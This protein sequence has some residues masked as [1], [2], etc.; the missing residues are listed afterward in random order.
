MD[1]VNRERVEELFRGVFNRLQT[2]GR[3]KLSQLKTSGREKFSQIKTAGRERLAHSA[4]ARQVKQRRRQSL[5]RYG[6]GAKRQ[7]RKEHRKAVKAYA[8]TLKGGDKNTQREALR[9]LR[10]ARMKS[11]ELRQGKK[12]KYNPGQKAPIPG[13]A[14]SPEL[15]GEAPGTQYRN[16]ATRR[17]ET[18]KVRQASARIY[19]R[20]AEAIEEMLREGKTTGS[21]L[22][23]TKKRVE[24]FFQSG[25]HKRK[26]LMGRLKDIDKAHR[27][28]AKAEKKKSKKGKQV[29]KL[30]GAY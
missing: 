11:R 29:R 25:A 9:H 1:D 28:E 7:A 23:A 8:K 12:I 22:E 24:K 4:R 30:H 27:I 21:D 15:R 6:S 14:A 20:F 18:K 3:E 10:N 17:A 5:G 26:G 19:K 13:K 16:R 2:S